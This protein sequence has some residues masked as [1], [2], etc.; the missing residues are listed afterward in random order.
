MKSI[1][2]VSLLL[3]G[4]ASAQTTH[5]VQMIIA[6]GESGTE[7][8]FEPTGLH[9][10]PGDTVRFLGVTP[11]H[12]VVAYHGQHGK[13]HRVPDG[14]PPFS[15]PI[16]PVTDSWEYTFAT[17]GTYDLW[18]GPHEPWGMAMRIVVG[19][20][21]GPAEAPIVDFSPEG[22]FGTAGTVLSDPALASSAIVEAGSVTWAQ[23]S[24]ESKIQAVPAN[25]LVGR[26]MQLHGAPEGE[27]P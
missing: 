22:V 17:E 15:S 10:E 7:F 13:S 16:V 4:A 25:E 3:L 26:I 8:Y 9:I 23:L 18:C 21:G 6:G 12:N 11:H 5:E 1:L 27:A 2:L 20:P 24:D 14:V 19:T